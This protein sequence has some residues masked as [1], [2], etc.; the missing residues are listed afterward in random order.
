M[1]TKTTLSSPSQISADLSNVNNISF[2]YTAAS[3]GVYDVYIRYATG[4]DCVSYIRV[5]QGTWVGVNLMSTSWWD[6]PRVA[7]VSVNM[8]AGSQT[9]VLTGTTNDGGWM[10]Y[11]FIDIIQ[12]GTLTDEEVAI[13]YATFFREQTSAG[14]TAQNDNL[15][16]WA[17][18]KSE[19]L[20]LSASAKDALLQAQMNLH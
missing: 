20:T 5:N 12:Q 11:D 9:I 8:Q 2:S 6:T 4:L 3:A 10:N 19:Y 15:I 1:G 7:H 18:L 16:P 17:Q 14:C 13:N